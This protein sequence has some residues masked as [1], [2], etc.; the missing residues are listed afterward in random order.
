MIATID[1]A[2]VRI[3]KTMNFWPEASFSMAVSDTSFVPEVSDGLI[4]CGLFIIAVAD[5]C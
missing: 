4:S 3:S 1:T 5:V 2:N